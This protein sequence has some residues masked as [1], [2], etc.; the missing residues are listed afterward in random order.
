[1]KRRIRPKNSAE[2]VEN[3]Q[4]RTSKKIKLDSFQAQRILENAF[5]EEN[6]EVIEWLKKERL[7]NLTDSNLS[8]KS[9]ELMI[10]LGFDINA[11]DKKNGDTALIKAVR[12]RNLFKVESIV[13]YGADT[14]ISN[15]HSLTVL[16][17]AI[18]LDYLN[19]AN[20]LLDKGENG[21]KEFMHAAREQDYQSME[22]L[23]G[24]FSNRGIDI[25]AIVLSKAVDEKD[26]KTIDLL[27]ENGL[28]VINLLDNAREGFVSKDLIQTL[29]IKGC[30]DKE[31]AQHYS[32]FQMLGELGEDVEVFLV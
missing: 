10:L 12:E 17:Y 1:M 3:S 31:E 14:S 23:I 13:D 19:I 2:G 7:V 25:E 4:Q 27:Q 30:I 18:Q 32:D 5:K 15:K 26:H 11:K 24:L 16:W 20:I 21:Y 29:F 22:R 9:I 6:D 8:I 28:D